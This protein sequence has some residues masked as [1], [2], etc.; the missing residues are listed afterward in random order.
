[1]ADED[2]ERGIALMREA[3]GDAAADAALGRHR[4][5][6]EN[7]GDPERT[8]F[9]VRVA[10][11]MM[12]HRPGLALRDR[13]LAILVCDIVL[14]RPLAM[15]DHLKLA[16]HSGVTRDEVEELLFQLSQ[17]CGFPT[18]REAGVVIRDVFAEVDAAAK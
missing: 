15:A 9:S 14:S 12:L 7:G 17:Y 1:M 4:A 3:L 13:A 6:V 2:F 8:D 11:G 5:A 18:V 16:L 10:W